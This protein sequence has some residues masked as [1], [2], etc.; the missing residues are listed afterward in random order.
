MEK[1][2][3]NPVHISEALDDALWEVGRRR[4]REVLQEIVARLLLSM[5]PPA[6]TRDDGDDETQ[7]GG[8]DG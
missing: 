2:R 8:H 1:L 5:A 7:G 4:T 3:V 6:P